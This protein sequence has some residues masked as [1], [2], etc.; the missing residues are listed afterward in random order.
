[1]HRRK[2]TLCLHAIAVFAAIVTIMAALRPQD[3]AQALSDNN[4]YFPTT[5][6]T[7]TKPLDVKRRAKGKRYK[8]QPSPIVEA[9]SDQRPLPIISH[10]W[11]GLSALPVEQSDAIIRGEV[12]N[13]QA[14]L[15]ED[16][17]GIYS[18]FTFKVCEVFKGYN[19]LVGPGQE[20]IADRL[21]GAVRFP[22][23]KSQHYTIDGQGMPRPGRQYVLFLKRNAE[24]EDFYIV[25]GYEL[26]SGSVNPLDGYASDDSAQLPF[27]VFKNAEEGAFLSALRDALVN[28]PKT[29]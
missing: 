21:G 26:R 16:R 7:A 17:T 20:I 1:M 29:Q 18:E 23:G 10:W 3:R 14:Y 27:A 11:R 24:D 19:Y 9:P 4:S 5:E 13:A 25:T 12:T 2:I 6:S 22:S 28:P 15:S 8:I